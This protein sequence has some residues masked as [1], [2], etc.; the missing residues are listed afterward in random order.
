MVPVYEKRRFDP[1]VVYLWPENLDAWN[2]YAKI[3]RQW[4]VT[5]MGEAIGLRA[6]GVE[7]VMRI[8]GVRRQDRAALLAK[9]QTMED[10]MLDAWSENR[11]G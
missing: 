9:I 11:D 5:A 4:N 1:P 7:A 10:A 3:R 6:E 2:F 8:C